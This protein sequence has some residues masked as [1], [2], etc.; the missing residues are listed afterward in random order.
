MSV[1]EDGRF[2]SRYLDLQKADPEIVVTEM[3]PA[4]RHVDVGRGF[5]IVYKVINVSSINKVT[6]DDTIQAK[7]DLFQRALQYMQSRHR[8]FA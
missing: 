4:R 3:P 8:I 6:N 2:L 1:P 5:E 7:S